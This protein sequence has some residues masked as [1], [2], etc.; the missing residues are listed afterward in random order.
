MG[1]KYYFIYFFR[2]SFLL[3]NLQLELKTRLNI[4]WSSS[5]NSLTFPPRLTE[6]QKRQKQSS[7]DVLLKSIE[8]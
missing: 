8:L 4:Q 5:N 2:N 6:V 3:E 7:G 1:M